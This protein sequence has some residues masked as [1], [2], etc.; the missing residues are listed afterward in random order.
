[1]EFRQFSGQQGFIA[2]VHLLFGLSSSAGVV[3]QDQTDQSNR[4][5]QALVAEWNDIATS[6]VTVRASAYHLLLHSRGSDLLG[7]PSRTDAIQFLHQE[8]LPIV[9]EKIKPERLT[10]S[11]D[12]FLLGRTMVGS[13]NDLKIV[14]S[15]DSLRNDETSI[16]GGAVHTRTR[17]IDGEV[18]YFSDI[19]QARVMQSQTNVRM[20]SPSDFWFIPTQQM[21]ASSERLGLLMEGETC[22][23]TQGAFRVEFSEA[24]HFVSKVVWTKPDGHPTYEIYQALPQT[25]D[26]YS[27]PYVSAMFHYKNV[28]GVDRVHLADLFIIQEAVIKEF[29]FA[30][31]I[32][33]WAKKEDHRQTQLTE[34]Y[35]ASE[36][37]R[38]HI[39]RD[40]RK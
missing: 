4:D 3:A 18:E 17:A 11:L 21:F 35:Q 16:M 28:H 33:L 2:L 13:W 29:R 8:L 22:V 9:S 5:A 23:L 37:F 36:E 39:S 12:G 31:G 15:G 34:V 38:L 14:M 20:L 19:G 1:M 25:F 27:L 32:D 24:S 6:V 26:G 40:R 7:C 10:A 30:E